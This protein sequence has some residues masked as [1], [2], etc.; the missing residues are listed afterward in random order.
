M[1]DLIKQLLD[2]I[3]YGATIIV[4]ISTI[5]AIYRW[6]TGISP[7]L[8]RLGKGLSSRKIAIFASGDDYNSLK[9]MLVDSGL[10]KESNVCQIAKQDCKKAEGYS[11]F[12][13]HWKSAKDHFESVLNVKKDATAL[14]VYAPQD[15]GILEK[16][17]IAK[18]NQHRNAIL[19]NMRGR[20][21]NDIVSSLITTSYEK[22]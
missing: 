19:V 5:I 10:F 11:L 2:Y 7:A 12:L 8:L 6:I 22:S 18:L 14:I 4:I 20:L 1:I 17:D 21:L 3:G 15:E 13:V 16:S 9:A